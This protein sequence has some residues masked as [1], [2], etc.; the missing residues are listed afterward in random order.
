MKRLVIALAAMV[1]L[2]GTSSAALAEWQPSGP[3]KLA[4]A[5]AAGGGADTISRQIADELQNG[6]AGKLS[7]NKSLAVAAQSW[8]QP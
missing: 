2:M 5:F 6:K 8:Q 4:I 1:S 7:H 3:I